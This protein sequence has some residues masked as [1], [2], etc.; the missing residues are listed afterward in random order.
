[1]YSNLFENADKE[2]DLLQNTLNNQDHEIYIEIKMAL[3]EIKE[4]CKA[5]NSL[6]IW[7]V[8]QKY[9]DNALTLLL[10]SQEKKLKDA[11]KY[12]V[13]QKETPEETAKIMENVKKQIQSETNRFKTQYN[14]LFDAL[15]LKQKDDLTLVP[16]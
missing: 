5:D 1:D 12:C 2:I 8:V 4:L 15:G 3:V 7:E 14:Y 10:S 16:A 9:Y 6:P 11:E 13:L